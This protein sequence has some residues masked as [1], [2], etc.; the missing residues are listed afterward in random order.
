MQDTVTLEGYASEKKS[1]WRRRRR[2]LLGKVGH[3]RSDDLIF[4]Y[5]KFHPNLEW[6]EPA[7][8]PRL[9]ALRGVTSVFLICKMI[10]LMPVLRA[11]VVIDDES[12]YVKDL[13]PGPGRHGN[14]TPVSPVSSL[15]PRPQWVAPARPAQYE[16]GHETQQLHTVAS[17]LAHSSGP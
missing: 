10:I 7:S 1:E 11:V 3:R 8:L 15:P 4:P 17:R 2:R 9:P 16:M 5:G 12:V 6:E 13:A 14:C